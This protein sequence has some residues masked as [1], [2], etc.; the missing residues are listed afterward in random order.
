MSKDPGADAARWL[1]EQSK[2]LE[3]ALAE[4]VTLNSFTGNV[5]GGNK[6]G[7]LLE[8]VFRADGVE[9]ERVRSESEKYADHLIVRSK[10]LSSAAPIALIGHLDTVF[11]PGTFEGYKRD[12]DLG[13]GP[14]VLDMKGGL[15]VVAWALKALS[16][17]G[18]LEALPQIRLV[19]VSDEEIGAPEGHKV[20]R[21]EV[22]GAQASLVFEAGRPKDLIITRRKGGGSVT[23]TAHGKAAHSGNAHKD[24]ANA[25]WALAKLIDR[26]QALTDYSRGLTLNVAKVAGGSENHT[27]PDHATAK[28]DIRFEARADA[29]ALIASLKGFAEEISVGVPGTRIEIEA[30]MKLD[31]LERTPASV[32]LMESYA[33]C[34]RAVGLSAGEAPVIGGGSNGGTTHSMGI[35]TIDGLGPRGIGF[36]TMNEHIEL[37][38]L[39]MKAKALALYLA[40]L[41]G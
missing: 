40:S 25:I 33:A 17:T 15:V 37:A 21:R 28:M 29:E 14:G 9:S 19:I 36:H 5:E 35:P 8:E 11:P 32:R 23:A 12:G 10:S 22:A 27:V 20:I 26:A 6:V 7:T 4:L 18:T 31:S 38:T 39:V 2:A 30:A 3:T 13:R 41:R 34:A 16:M 1:D 24:G